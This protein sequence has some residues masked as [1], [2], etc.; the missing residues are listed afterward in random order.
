MD[1]SAKP[2]HRG[3][4]G[5]TGS[6]KGVGIREWLAKDKPRRLIVWDPLGEYS[7]FV[8]VTVGSIADLARYLQ[9]R[10]AFRVALYPGPNAEKFAPVFE[11]F[12]R[13]VWSVGDCDCLIEELADVTRASWAPPPF[14]RLSKQGRHRRVRLRGASQR[15]ADVDK[16]F[17]QACTY[18]RC[19]ML[20]GRP[21]EKAMAERMKVPLADIQAL[22]TVEA[23]NVTTI[24]YIEKDFR[25]GKTTN[26]RK[27]LRRK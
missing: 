7:A 21:D 26:G 5:A 24:N 4:F 22:R 10:K 1:N 13:V 14:R 11:L 20:E 23:G 16:A 18:I 25:T 9:G 17:L 2:D 15:P 19:H 6:G 12:C 3:W 27:V 8:D